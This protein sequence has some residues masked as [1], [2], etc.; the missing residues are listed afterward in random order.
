MPLV[1]P[2]R[3]Q[4]VAAGLLGA[5]GLA[6]APLSIWWA[7]DNGPG[8]LTVALSHRLPLAASN[9]IDV[10]VDEASVSVTAIGADPFLLLQSPPRP[11]RSVRVELLPLAPMRRDFY[12]YFIPA[13]APRSET[14]SERHVQRGR[15][16]AMPDAWRVEW[17]FKEPIRSYRLDVP[18]DARFRVITF[19]AS[20]RSGTLSTRTGSPVWSVVTAATAMTLL[21]LALQLAWRPFVPG[22]QTTTRA[23]AIYLLVPAGVLVFM[24]PPFQ[25]PDE[26][27]HWKLALAAVR[28]A[29]A[30]E[31][32]AYSLPDILDPQKIRFRP[33]AKFDPARLATAA[34]T[35]AATSSEMETEQQWLRRN[36]PYVRPYAYPTVLLV[37]SVFP[38]IDGVTQALILYYLS[39]MVSAGLLVL[40]LVIA[41]R[42]HDVPFTALFFFS[43]PLV[44]QQC[45]VV[46][47]D[48][49]LNL[50]ALVSVLLFVAIRQRPTP[51]GIA[52]LGV[53]TMLIVGVKFIYAP[54]L[55]LP[56]LLIQPRR[57]VLTAAAVLAILA[58]YPA[59]LLILHETRSMAEVMQRGREA[60]EQ[61]AFLT[62]WAGWREFAFVYVRHLD[63]LRH[64]ASWA[65]PLGWVDT[66]LGETHIGLVRA[67]AATAVALDVW[68]YLPGS[69][70]FLRTRWR[71]V[72]LLA[73]AAL[74]GLLF[75]TF[76]DVL[77]YYIMETPAHARDVVGPQVRHY[78]PCAIVA[79]LLPLAL[80]SNV[81]L[82]SNAGRTE[83]RVSLRTVALVV[84]IT[85]LGGRTILLV[86]DLLLR[87]W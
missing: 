8:D 87:Y 31:P 77:L 76:G 20:E 51:A 53:L 12:I 69:G 38:R 30:M 17:E 6:I 9:S 66:P 68:R 18:E 48:V 24:L 79:L 50:G 35:T 59:L 52:A 85:L 55:A 29:A 73:T 86:Q 33:E 81:G 60:N 32:S 83:H 71:A 2:K 19:E 15:V 7:P 36:Y 34:A 28:P 27:A 44:L 21:V 64:P 41:T 75:V 46:S 25:G 84:T 37:S 78:F 13:S 45:A 5:L 49:F 70:R 22:L 65:G 16:A 62:T 58:A 54:L 1:R 10:D 4:R 40:L 3:R 80:G 67:S 26:W 74:G 57:R 61:I 72:L 39:R 11:V 63:M 56:M 42:R 14:F 47:A 23:I 82:D 43:L